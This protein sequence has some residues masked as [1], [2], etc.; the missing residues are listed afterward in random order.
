MSSEKER[1]LRSIV[2]DAQMRR[3]DY[4]YF[5]VLMVVLAVGWLLLALLM[6]SS[7]PDLRT[8]TV[9]GSG[10][11]LVCAAFF[12]AYA[13]MILQPALNAARSNLN[14]HIDANDLG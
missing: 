10:V 8:M 11:A 6:P 13:G 1:E 12:H 4:R 3:S 14:S 5:E 2:I 7:M 9:W